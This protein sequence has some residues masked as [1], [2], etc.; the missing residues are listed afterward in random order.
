[1]C[2]QFP[3]TCSACLRPVRHVGP[4]LVLYST[5]SMRRGV[6]MS[7]YPHLLQVCQAAQGL[8]QETRSRPSKFSKRVQDGASCL[9]AG[10]DAT[11]SKMQGG[12]LTP[13]KETCI[14]VDI[15]HQTVHHRQL[16]HHLQRSMRHKSDWH[17]SW[18]TG[19]FNSN[20]LALVPSTGCGIPRDVNHV[21][22]GGH[23]TEQPSC[24]DLISRK[25][26]VLMGVLLKAKSNIKRNNL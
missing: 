13:T 20:A 26:Q 9:L 17:N 14:A 11:R 4:T 21:P 19:Q 23:V 5:M 10:Y 15:G 24:V 12:F 22:S 7:S 3:V 1:M 6:S 16:R 8:L 25:C 18:H 2:A